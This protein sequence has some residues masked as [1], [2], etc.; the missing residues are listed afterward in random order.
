MAADSAQ[1]RYRLRTQSVEPVFEISKQV[2]G[3]RQ[4]LLRGLGKV[5][6][7]WLLVTCIYNLKRVAAL[8]PYHVMAIEF[9]AFGRWSD[10]PRHESGSSISPYAK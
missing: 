5:E 8:L 7:E 3:F 2:L 9:P 10:A 1:R 6:F 4:F